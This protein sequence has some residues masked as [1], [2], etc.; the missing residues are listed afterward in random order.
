MPFL[1]LVLCL[2]CLTLPCRAD[3]P[4]SEDAAA[5]RARVALKQ[6]H[7][8]WRLA[9]AELLLAE[10]RLELLRQVEGLARLRYARAEGTQQDALRAQ[11]ELMRGLAGVPALE[12]ETARRRDEWER[13]A[14]RA[15]DEA[16]SSS[17]GAFTLEPV[18]ADDAPWLER[19]RALSPG[20]QAERRTRARLE[21]LRALERALAV[22][23]DGLL[24]QGELA[25]ES[26]VGGYESGRLPL[27]ALLEALLAQADDGRARLRLLAEHAA[28]RA[29]LEEGVASGDAAACVPAVAPGR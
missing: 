22:Y 17:A 18:G 29:E 14:G 28:R 11:A 19:A 13:R 9:R 3:S 20:A 10:G 27:Q 26:A 24:P 15:L 16:P 6:A 5:A 7:A 2:A 25:L 8:A 23:D 12:A 1:R 4:L 21:Q